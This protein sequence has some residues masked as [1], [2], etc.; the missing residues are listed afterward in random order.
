[1]R[2]VSI[3]TDIYVHYSAITA[4]M[5]AVLCKPW[6][7]GFISVFSLQNIQQQKL[8]VKMT[9][10]FIGRVPFQLP[11]QNPHPALQ[12]NFLTE[13]SNEKKP[14][15]SKMGQSVPFSFLSPMVQEQKLCYRFLW[16]GCS[17]CRADQP[18]HSH[19]CDIQI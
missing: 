10:D 11:N 2:T 5:A 17:S 8:W 3:N 1:M 13:Q 9:P 18:K 7:A 19:L 12:E 16:A 14:P 4:S 15:S 6:L